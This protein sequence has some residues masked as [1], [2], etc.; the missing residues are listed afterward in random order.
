M[1]PAHPFRHFWLIVLLVMG[2][3]ACG[4]PRQQTAPAAP[5]LT[6]AA[7][8]LEAADA[9]YR[10]GCYAKA[11]G[12]Y[13]RA[14]P[15]LVSGDHVDQMAICLNNMGN[16]YLRMSK[17]D[18]ALIFFD[19]A[20]DM[21]A[22]AAGNRLVHAIW[23]NKATALIRLGDDKAAQGAL[24]E[25]EKLGFADGPE[26]ARRWT[27]DALL[28]LR[29]GETALARARLSEASNAV[30]AQDA[31]ITAVIEFTLGHMAEDE[32]ALEAGYAHYRNALAADRRQEFY[33]GMADDLKAMGDI[34]RKQSRPGEA[35]VYYKRSISLYALVDAADEASA[36]KPALDEAAAAAGQT[37]DATLFFVDD[38]LDNPAFKG[39]CE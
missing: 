2:A 6:R 26:A 38:W 4:G 1:H 7:K 28:H 9:W 29:R 19:E 22:R 3:A 36:L 13:R 5:A 27:A 25:A 21:A 34:R 10:K 24:A 23:V 20:L 17:P 37:I 33:R 39:P 15:E 32:G 11:L 35:A 14:Y 31:A 18:S 12:Y 30:S 8:T 16:A